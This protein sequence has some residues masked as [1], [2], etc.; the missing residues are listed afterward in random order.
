MA[1]WPLPKALNILFSCVEVMA[2]FGMEIEPIKH[3]EIFL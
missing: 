2:I 1:S 3:S